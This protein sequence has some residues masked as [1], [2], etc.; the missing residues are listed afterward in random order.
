MEDS[1]ITEA[2]RLLWE[3]TNEKLQKQKEESD[4]MICKCGHKHKDHSVRYSINYTAGMCRKCE[5]ENFL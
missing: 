2:R 1:R 3:V 4:N 5:C